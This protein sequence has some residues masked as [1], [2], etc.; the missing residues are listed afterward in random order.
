MKQIINGLR[1]D[2]KTAQLIAEWSNGYNPNDFN[3]VAEDLYKT[4]KGTYFIAG[5]GGPSSKYSQQCGNGL[6]GGEDVQ[7]VTVSQAF[8]WLEEKGCID[9]IE[10]EFGDKIEDA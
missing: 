8:D 9:A 4:K 1:Y 10:K 6:C 2:T 5:Q 7:K 3:W